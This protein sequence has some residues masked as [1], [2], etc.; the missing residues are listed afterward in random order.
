M[1]RVYENFPELLDSDPSKAKDRA[2]LIQH[3]LNE[4]F[5]DYEREDILRFAQT[6]GQPL[7][8]GLPL[9]MLRE[10]AKELFDNKEVWRANTFT[11]YFY[12]TAYDLLDLGEDY[13][14]F[15]NKLF[16]A[17]KDLDYCLDTYKYKRILDQAYKVQL[18]LNGERRANWKDFENNNDETDYIDHLDAL[19][20][21]SYD[22]YVLDLLNKC[23]SGSNS[24]RM[25]LVSY[26]VYFT[27]VLA[28]RFAESSSE[29]CRM[30]AA[31][32]CYPSVFGKLYNDESAE[33]KRCLAGNPICPED[34]MEGFVNR[35][36]EEPEDSSDY[37]A[38]CEVAVRCDFNLPVYKQLLDLPI[39]YKYP[40]VQMIQANP[41]LPE[42]K[43]TGDELDF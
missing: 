25:Q 11:F 7:D 27:E 26:S 13:E 2:D 35:Y 42:D 14:V 1:N 15:S 10:E 36:M 32:S 4:Y 41:T 6:L 16:E 20:V 18:W 12:D 9:P 34:L 17:I 29:S 38:V 43:Q 24:R 40:F 39:F 8:S 19:T 21:D 30:A 33:V 23:E 5:N 31:N 37:L 22:L 3:L 28:K